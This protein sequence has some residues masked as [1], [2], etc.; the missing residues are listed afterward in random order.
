MNKTIK[1]VI[2]CM[3]IS[4]FAC[5]TGD[6]NNEPCCKPIETQSAGSITLTTDE[7]SKNGPLNDWVEFPIKV[8]HDLAGNSNLNVTVSHSSGG[9]WKFTMCYSTQCFIGD[10]SHPI[11]KTINLLPDTDAELDIRIL[12]PEAAGSDTSSTIDVVVESET[13]PRAIGSLSLTAKIQ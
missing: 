10:S 8:R 1:V 7:S 6:K 3:C 2:L 5:S 12:T 4:L 9:K 13:A 11:K